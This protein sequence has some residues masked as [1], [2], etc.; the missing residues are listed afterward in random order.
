MVKYKTMK[1]AFLINKKILTKDGN[2]F[3][4]IDVDL[5]EILENQITEILGFSVDNVLKLNNQ[6]FVAHINKG[7][8]NDISKYRNI[9]QFVSLK[10]ISVEDLKDE[11]V[12][13]LTNYVR[14]YYS[15]AK[16][17][18]KFIEPTD[19]TATEYINTQVFGFCIDQ[20]KQCCLVRDEGEDAWTLPGGGCE[21]GES[22]VDAFVREVS[23][24]AQVSIADIKILGYVLVTVTKSGD[25]V[26]EI[27][28]CRLASKISKIEEFVKF[29][30][31]FETAERK[32][33]DLS[34][35]SKYVDWM[36]FDVGKEV[37]NRLE[38]YL[39]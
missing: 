28:Q 16:F 31:G 3:W 23:E 33:V 21:F 4:E 10:E 11:N 32:F 26:E 37:Q 27:V 30:D 19:A 6:C 14:D 36:N 7:N 34:E 5:N 25:I 39:L 8:I 15:E 35:V 13:T 29:K 20:N 12:L 9:T 22:A 2:Y 24:E 17:D 18:F 1:I 38:K